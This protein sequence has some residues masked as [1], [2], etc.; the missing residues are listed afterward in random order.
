MDDDLA[1]SSGS[2][3][4]ELVTERS[5]FDRAAT[6]IVAGSL[7]MG[8]LRGFQIAAIAAEA[9]AL[10]TPWG[11]IDAMTRAGHDFIARGLAGVVLAALVR[12]LGIGVRAISERPPSSPTSRD[13]SPEDEFRSE[14][15]A[16]VG[17]SGS[18]EEAVDEDLAAVRRLI[19]LG[20]WSAADQ[21]VGDLLAERPD[22]RRVERIAD[23][24]RSAKRTIGER[25]TEQLRAAREVNDPNRVLELYAQTPPV[26]DAEDRRNLDQELAGWFLSLVHRR[27]RGGGVQLEI[28]TLAERVSESFAHTVE[29]ASLR[30]ALPTLRRSVGLCPRCGR[31][32]NG[33]ADACPVCLTGKTSMGPEP[34][35]EPEPELEE[36]D[37][38]PV[39][40]RDSEWFVERGDEDTPA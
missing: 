25:W 13:H 38:P 4:S 32:Y 29:G 24:L 20:D 26:Q 37:E 7:A 10:E 8:A 17:R 21:R 27:L 34:E 18:D 2:T 22:D 19:E 1:A 30:A 5:W 12:A 14:P 3:T 39:E 28:V 36:V 15:A 40:N 35:S 31:P 16:P 33:T 9:G 6:W 11:W 23:E